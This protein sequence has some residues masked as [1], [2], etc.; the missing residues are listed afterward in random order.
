MDGA[1]IRCGGTALDLRR[2]S[3]EELLLTLAKPVDGIVDLGNAQVSV[4]CDDPATWPADIRLDGFSY[5]SL[6]TRAEQDRSGTDAMTYLSDSANTSA[7]ILPARDRLVWLGRSSVGYRP[8]PYEQLAAFYRRM[9]HDDQARKVLH[10]KQRRRRSTQGFGGKIWGY[11]LDC[12]IG[13]GYQ[14]WLAAIW[15]VA[16]VTM[17]GIVFAWRP[18]PPLDPATSQHFNSLVYTI[19]LLLPVG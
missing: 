11:L 15:L 13:Y 7:E 5:G 8:Q 9:G 12:F 6:I 16:L 17:G 18:P 2:L 14:P 3:A 4:L 10:A 19:N 1:I